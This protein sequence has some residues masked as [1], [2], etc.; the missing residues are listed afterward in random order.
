MSGYIVEGGT[1][2]NV[3]PDYTK[4]EYS[5][6]CM[7]ELEMISLVERVKKCIEAAALATGCEVDITEEKGYAARTFSHTLGNICR[8]ALE[9]VDEEVLSGFPDD[10]GST[11]FGNVSQIMPTANPYFSLNPTRV[12]LHTPEYERLAIQPISHNAIERSAKAMSQTI[13]ECFLDPQILVQAK[14]ERKD[15]LIIDTKPR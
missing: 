6:R 7:E 1:A 11:D 5:V 12:S 15:S 10:F 9:D 3:I 13:I 4:I 2:S 8:S 14:N